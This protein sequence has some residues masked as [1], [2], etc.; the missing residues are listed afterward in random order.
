VPP[1]FL[2]DPFRLLPSFQA[3]SD[4]A[5]IIWCTSQYTHTDN[6][7]LITAYCTQQ[8]YG[9]NGGNDEIGEIKGNI[10]TGPCEWCCCAGVA[11]FRRLRVFRPPCRAT[12]SPVLYPLSRKPALLLRPAWPSTS[13]PPSARRTCTGDTPAMT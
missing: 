6:N 8:G 2:M 5:H 13:C 7:D 9:N 10:Y 12:L 1:T 11:V 4:P 3:V